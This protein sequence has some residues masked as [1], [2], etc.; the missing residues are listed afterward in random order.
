VSLFAFTLR[1]AL[2]Q[3]HQQQEITRRVAAQKQ[4]AASHE[5]IG[6][7]LEA[8][9]R[10]TIEITQI[11]ELGSLLQACASRK[12]VF[13]LI[14][15]RLRLLFPDASGCISLFSA[16]RNRVESVAKWGICPA[17]Q[18]FMPEDCWA[19][20]RGRT[21]AHPGGHSAPRCPHLIGEGPS[22][23]IPLIAN[24]AAFGTLSIQND[25]PLSPFQTQT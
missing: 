4:L 9:R 6:Q 24:G 13:R 19:L 12:E 25:D 11:S 5:K 16:S 20:R 7:L 3:F 21:H 15:E 23:C 17:D 10:Q 8:A 18:I 22:V 14:P 2:T 1:L